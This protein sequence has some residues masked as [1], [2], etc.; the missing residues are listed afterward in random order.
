MLSTQGRTSEIAPVNLIYG[1]QSVSDSDLEYFIDAFT[2][3]DQKL[4]NEYLDTKE[5]M[6]GLSYRFSHYSPLDSENQ[7]K[8]EI[9]ALL[10]RLEKWFIKAIESSKGVSHLKILFLQKKQYSIYGLDL[11]QSRKTEL[12]AGYHN[13]VYQT[14][15]NERERQTIHTQLELIRSKVIGSYPGDYNE[16]LSRFERGESKRLIKGGLNI[17]E[18]PPYFSCNYYDLTKGNHYPRTK[19]SI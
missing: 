10:M 8:K 5:T 18:A 11:P 3:R 14:E 6:M 2:L 13:L 17:V 12:M 7:K 15:I 1:I 9:D 19:S 4:R 16:N